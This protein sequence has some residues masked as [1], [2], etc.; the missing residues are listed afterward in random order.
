MNPS[1]Y[2]NLI[3]A[4]NA[5]CTVPE[6]ILIPEKQIVSKEV[7]E[8]HIFTAK[9]PTTTRFIVRSAVWSEDKDTETRAG[10][11]YSSD[12]VAHDELMQTVKSV[13][14]ENR[15]RAD[16]ISS[17][18]HVDVMVSIFIDSETGGVAFSPWL[19]FFGHSLVEYAKTPKLAVAGQNAAQQI[20]AHDNSFDSTYV[21]RGKRPPFFKRLAESIALLKKKFP[22]P[23][24][25]EWSYANKTLYILQVRP[26]IIAP[27]ALTMTPLEKITSA[28]TT[29]TA[30]L[31]RDD[32]S[33]SL[34]K[35]SPLS[36]E[37]LD[38]LY[39]DSRQ[40]WEAFHIRGGAS[41]LTRLKNGEVFTDTKKYK[42]YMENRRFLSPFLRA[43]HQKNTLQ[44][45]IQKYKNWSAPSDISYKH[46][47]EA[48]CNWHT[49][50][51]YEFLLSGEHTVRAYPG[52]YE[53]LH[54]P[55][56]NY[57]EGSIS[58]RWKS[59]FMRTLVPLR[60]RVLQRPEMA[61]SLFAD[62]LKDQCSLHWEKRYEAE[63]PLSI[64]SIQLEAVSEYS[65]TT[66]VSGA[67]CTKPAKVIANPGQWRG[68]LPE[69][70]IIVTSHIPMSWIPELPYIAGIM[71]VQLGQLSHAAIV[72]REHGVSAA[73]IP[74]DTLTT[75]T[76]GNSVTI[77]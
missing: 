13:W 57:G 60:E 18:I 1:K 35:L 25:V 73:V 29:D 21:L 14:Q 38:T 17:N 7:R 28:H 36:F 8:I 59:A 11:F 61:W 68:P 70:V 16:T 63:L 51:A 4:R 67:P 2:H 65:S 43:L 66:R 75:A 49:A 22:G 9:F 46:I 6:T 3:R 39:G 32:F 23:I 37:L 26:V 31:R 69:G 72:L 47:R 53:L 58:S 77:P 15:V 10:F 42:Q 33:V 76:D 62:V 20:I 45:L 41:F 40:Y 50:Q 74:R 71:S 30:S 19:Y 54:I 52:E 48:F 55:H 34:G 56:T 24:D 12:S 44:D 27:S 5:G 64:Y